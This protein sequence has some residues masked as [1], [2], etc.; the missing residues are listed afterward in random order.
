[1]KRRLLFISLALVLVWTALVPA[2]PA[3]AKPEKTLFTGSGLIYVT[4]MPDALQGEVREIKNITW[5]K[6]LENSQERLK[7]G[8]RLYSWRLV[9]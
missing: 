8:Q 2:A 9:Q 1:M 4:D 6:R 7:V 3:L 5:K